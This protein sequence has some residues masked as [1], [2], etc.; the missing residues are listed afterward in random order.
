MTN[1]NG[2]PLVG[3]HRGATGS[4]AENT[5]ATFDAAIALHADF[6]E[7]DIRRTADGV[8]VLHHD[9]EICDL[10]V[11]DTP[12]ADLQAASLDRPLATLEDLLQVAKGNIGLDLELKESGYEPQ[13]AATLRAH[14]LDP[15]TFVITSFLES[16]VRLFK[17]SYPEAKCGLLIEDRSGRKDFFPEGRLQ[18]CGA[19]FVAAENRL[20]NPD[21]VRRLAAK[22]FPVWVWTVNDPIRIETLLAMPGIAA[23]ITDTLDVAQS[24]QTKA[25]KN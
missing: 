14:Q 7:T 2:V 5:M 3:A 11:C 22:N 13:I 23:V 1:A 4:A 12:F 24:E 8:L 25:R 21:F 6:I 9:P 19:D 17:K 16:A 10:K 20:V 15:A 18:R